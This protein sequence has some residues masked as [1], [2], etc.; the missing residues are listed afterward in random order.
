MLQL[1]AGTEPNPGPPGDKLKATDHVTQSL[2]NH[3]SKFV[4]PTRLHELG[5]HLDLREAQI[6]HIL[7]RTN[8]TTTNQAFK[9]LLSALSVT[10]C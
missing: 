1:M 10:F 7:F 3:I 6:E 9:V 8:S 4:L 2:L 5:R